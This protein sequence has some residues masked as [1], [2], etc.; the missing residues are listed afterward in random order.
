MLLIL[1]FKHHLEEHTIK[2]PDWIK[3]TEVQNLYYLNI[4]YC[5]FKRIPAIC[6]NYWDLF[7]TSNT[8][9]VIPGKSQA[10]SFPGEHRSSVIIEP[11]DLS[12]FI[13]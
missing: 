3:I 2:T 4:L 11:I 7:P 5:L 9:V 6:T 13:C 1:I 12:K 10:S 8:N